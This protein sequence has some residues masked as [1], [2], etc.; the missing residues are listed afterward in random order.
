MWCVGLALMA[1]ATLLVTALSHCDIDAYPLP[2]ESV[3]A[4]RCWESTYST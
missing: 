4:V 1:G 2:L 3:C